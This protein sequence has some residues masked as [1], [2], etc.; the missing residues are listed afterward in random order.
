MRQPDEVGHR[1]F[2]DCGAAAAQAIEV[3]L[4]MP[5]ASVRSGHSTVRRL[6]FRKDYWRTAS[7]A[8]GPILRRVGIGVVPISLGK[9]KDDH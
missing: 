9:A 8:A 2:H 5:G 1:D 4:M 6:G 7:D 3:D